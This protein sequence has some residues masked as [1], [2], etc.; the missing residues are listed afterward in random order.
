MTHYLFWETSPPLFF[1]KF[2]QL[3]ELKGAP[4]NR[5]FS[6]RN[7]LALIPIFFCIDFLGKYVN[8]FPPNTFLFE[9]I[10]PMISYNIC[11]MLIFCP[12]K[13]HQ[14]QS[15]WHFFFTRNQ[16]KKLPF[17]ILGKVKD[18]QDGYW[19]YLRDIVILYSEAPPPGSMRVKDGLIELLTAKSRF[20]CCGDIRSAVIRKAVCPFKM[21]Q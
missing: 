9:T 14:A 18:F 4:Q 15:V 10:I 13:N 19:L 16:R 12:P 7:F 6:G 20:L 11:K 5:P 2:F 21:T 8:S 17:F 3:P 1:C